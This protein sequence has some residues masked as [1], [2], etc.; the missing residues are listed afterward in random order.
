MVDPTGK[1]RGTIRWTEYTAISRHRGVGTWQVVCALTPQHAQV[2]QPGWRIRITDSDGTII[3]GPV[4]R[5]RIQITK[6]R[7][8]NRALLT[9]GGTDD[10][11][12][13]QKRE[14]WPSPTQSITNQTSA[15]NVRTGVASTIIRLFV[16][17][18]AGPSAASTGRRVP[19]LTVAADPTVGASGTWRAR[20]DPLLEVLEKIA[21]AGAVSGVELGYRI[22]NALELNKSF[23]VY[24]PQDLRGPA[25]FSLGLR[26]I[27]SLTWEM[28]A[29]EA[30]VMVAGGRGEETAREFTAVIDAAAVSDWGRLEEFY[31]YRSASDSDSGVELTQGATTR[32]TERAEVRTVEVEPIDSP[33]LRY[34][35]H[36]GLGDV[37]TVGIID[38]LTIDEVIREVEITNSRGEGK[39]IRPRIGTVG[40][41][42]MA[43]GRQRPTVV[44]LERRVGQL[45]KR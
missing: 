23:V 9:L 36:Y 43:R 13:L 25:R 6:G 10:M 4:R 42:T 29:P 3:S 40:L 31:D 33:T 32:L 37:V 17:A 18:N 26:N 14:A 39:K 1:P 20:F 44:D 2:A 24:L 45:E 21:V 12:Y 8:G 19:N 34:G 38:G 30:T 27:R 16:D 5:A 15:Y 22:D 41:S 7:N 11:I 28:V 35:E